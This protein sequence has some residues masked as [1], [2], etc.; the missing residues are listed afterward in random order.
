MSWPEYKSHTMNCH[1]CLN[2]DLYIDALRKQKLFRKKG[3]EISFPRKNG[4]L[5]TQ[6][7]YQL[8]HQRKSNIW[9]PDF[10]P[11]TEVQS[12]HVH[13]RSTHNGFDTLCGKFG[14]G[15]KEEWRDHFTQ[16]YNLILSN[17]WLQKCLVTCQCR[18]T[19]IDF[20]L[21]RNTST[22]NYLNCKMILR[23]G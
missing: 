1:F 6:N 4:Y 2:E 15:R 12:F 21:V 23:E 20:L 16:S 7:E 8:I 17:T 5:N 10:T 13:V 9:L 14:Y 18:P 11:I 19:H 22:K 3:V